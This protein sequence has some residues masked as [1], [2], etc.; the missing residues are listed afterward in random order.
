MDMFARWFRPWRGQGGCASS[1]G[2]ERRGGGLECNR[3]MPDTLP[4]RNNYRF[5]QGSAPQL[6]IIVAT[7]R[8]NPREK[9]HELGGGITPGV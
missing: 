6:G 2:P 9:Q 5:Q 4:R 3:G 7:E 8:Q 1:G